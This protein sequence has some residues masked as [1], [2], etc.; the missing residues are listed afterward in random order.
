LKVKLYDVSFSPDV[1]S[2]KDFRSLVIGATNPEKAAPGSLRRLLRDMY[3]DLD[4][5]QQPRTAF[6]GIHAS[7][8]PI[9]G[10][11]EFQVW[12]DREPA[13][14]E[15]G[16]AFL[17]KGMSPGELDALMENASARFQGTEGPG[18]DITEDA[19]SRELPGNIKLI[20]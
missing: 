13:E 17:K 14:H 9:E 1:L 4:L 8:G 2:W 12:L 3:Q 16:A 19:D 20:D 18:F 11:R 6:N 15:L 5:E 7:A 10:L